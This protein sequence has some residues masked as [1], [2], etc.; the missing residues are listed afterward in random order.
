MRH[1]KRGK[2]EIAKRGT[3]KKTPPP[4]LL[5]I[6]IWV[7]V[8]R[9]QKKQKWVST[10]TGLHPTKL[11]VFNATPKKKHLHCVENLCGGQNGGEGA[12]LIK[13]SNIATKNIAVEKKLLNNG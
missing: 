5:F 7:N 12:G 10:N 13:K 6:V 8:F 9:I 3:L 4:V 2:E 11:C 1:C